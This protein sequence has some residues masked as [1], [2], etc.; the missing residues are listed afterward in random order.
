MA[1]IALL[2]AV[3]VAFLTDESLVPGDHRMDWTGT[4][5]LVVG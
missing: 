2:A 4:I 3:A 5:A 1:V